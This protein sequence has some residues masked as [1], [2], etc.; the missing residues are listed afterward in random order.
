MPIICL[1]PVYKT[2][3][4]YKYIKLSLKQIHWQHKRLFWLNITL[5]TIVLDQAT[6]M[7]ALDLL[8]Y[9]QPVIVITDWFQFR[10]LYNPGAAF[11]LLADAGAWK[12]LFFFSIGSI[13]SL[14]LLLWLWTG[15]ALNKKLCSAICLIIGGAAGNL[16][17]RFHYSYVIDFI[18]LHYHNLYYY[19]AF[20]IADSAITIG[21]LLLIYDS[22][23]DQQ[24][25]NQ[26][27][28]TR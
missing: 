2:C 10:L 13:I 21:A 23:T 28:H 20:N 5:I 11:S 6:K 26:T 8:K 14:A 27:Q 1:P 12:H 17:D 24:H 7:L 9:N 22:F 3:N 4:M 16:I 15:K 19:P 18:Q 25:K